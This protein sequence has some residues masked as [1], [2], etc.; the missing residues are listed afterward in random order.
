MEEKHLE[1][2]MNKFLLGTANEFEKKQLNDWYEEMNSRDVTWQEDAPNE[3]KMI[4]E[5]MRNNLIKHMRNSNKPKTIK[6]VSTRSW[7]AAAAVLTGLSIGAYLYESNLLFS[8]PIE[9]SAVASRQNTENKYILLPD[10]STVLL[11]PGSRLHYSFNRNIREVTLVGEAYF[12]IKHKK[13]PFVIHTGKVIT[14]VLG[15]AFNIKAY[16]GRSVIVSVTRGKV[17]VMDASKKQLVILTPNQEVQYSTDTKS[18]TRQNTPAAKAISWVK[19]DMQFNEIA[20]GELASKLER[21]YGIQIK[22]NNPDLQNCPITGHFKGTESI[23]EVFKI[24][25]ATLSSTYVID[26]NSVTIDGKSCKQ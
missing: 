23:D 14:T 20:F 24:I 7:W 12:D 13:Q 26:G 21:R 3:A 22:F 1:S 2:L 8:T 25:S 15:T 10:S 16:A 17:S 6:R 11:H 9:I 19:A 5:M 18:L 4:E